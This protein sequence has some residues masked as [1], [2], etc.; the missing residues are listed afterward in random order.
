MPIIFDAKPDSG[1]DDLLPRRYHF[2]NNY[3]KVAEAAV[4]DWILFRKPRRGDGAPGYFA[5][6]RLKALEPDPKDPGSS[7]ALLDGF[8]DFDRAVP[9]NRADGQP[10]EEIMR[11][12]PQKGR[13]A[14]I[15]GRS[16]RPVSTADFA[17][18]VKA[19]LSDVFDPANAIKLELDP[20][21]CDADTRALI[22]APE[23]AQERQIRQILLNRKIRD[24]AFP[25]AVCTAY[26]N[27]CAIT[28]L[29]IVNGGGK[30]E[31]QAAHIWPVEGDGPDVV[32]SGLALSGTV[33]WLFDRGL[34]R[35]SDD[36]RLLISHNKIPSELQRLFERQMSG[37]ILPKN[38]AHWPNRS[39]L[40]RHR[41]RFS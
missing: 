10:Y 29:K 12:A 4:G 19:G 41:E 9:Q 28:G 32:Q 11:S 1:Y 18:I 30:V 3:L 40:Q 22:D 16:V 8:L 36:Y 37:I 35:I 5:V 17:A 24:A 33:H 13:G 23:E 31:V 39:Y 21:H 20:D 38:E 7:Y 27:T 6:A 15:Q 14:A 26:D 2:P 34:I 25:S